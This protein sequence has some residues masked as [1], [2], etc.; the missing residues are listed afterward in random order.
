M[1]LRV[2]LPEPTDRWLPPGDPTQE[3]FLVPTRSESEGAYYPAEPSP[4][5]LEPREENHWG[6]LYTH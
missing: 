5:Y 3:H 6:G 1:N 2:E 4:R